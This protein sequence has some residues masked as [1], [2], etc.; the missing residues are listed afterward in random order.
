MKIKENNM[1]E[2]VVLSLVIS[3]SAL[4]LEIEEQY[5]IDVCNGAKVELA[6]PTNKYF[7]GVN[8][9]VLDHGNKYSLDLTSNIST[10]KRVLNFD[11]SGSILKKEKGLTIKTPNLTYDLMLL[12]KE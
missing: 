7:S 6:N 2:C 11:Y 1:L 4:N 3:G 12:E 5:E 9:K 8:L 10:D